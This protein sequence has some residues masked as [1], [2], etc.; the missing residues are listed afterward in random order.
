MH[1]QSEAENYLWI[2]SIARNV[3]TSCNKLSL[4]ANDSCFKATNKKS[5]ERLLKY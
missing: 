4:L 1:N 2:Y 3:G 5:P